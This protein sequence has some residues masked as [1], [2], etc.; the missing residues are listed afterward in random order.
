MRKTFL[1]FSP[2]LI[3]EEESAAVVATLHSDRIITGPKARQFEAE[4]VCS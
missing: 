3:G 1:P 2:P 4:T